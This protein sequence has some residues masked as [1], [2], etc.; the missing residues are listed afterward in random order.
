MAPHTDGVVDLILSL[1]TVFLAEEQQL[2]ASGSR[3]NGNVAVLQ[4]LGEVCL[5]GGCGRA[6]TLLRQL[7]VIWSLSSTSTDGS[8]R[9]GRS[10]VV[11]HRRNSSPFISP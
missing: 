11:N 10:C 3:W 6:S 5:P 9:D 4:P 7:A 1:W 2:R 8:G